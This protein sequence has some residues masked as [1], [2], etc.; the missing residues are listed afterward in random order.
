[1]VGT[2]ARLADSDERIIGSPRLDVRF[3]PA[4]GARVVSVRDT[5]SGREWLVPPAPE[6][7]RPYGASYTEGRL[8]FGWD[9][10]VPTIDECLVGG[11]SY[12]DHGELWAVP[13]T[14]LAPTVAGGMRFAAECRR[15]PLTLEREISVEGDAVA[16]D[17]VLRNRGPIAVAAFWAM[18]PFFAVSRDARVRFSSPVDTA[19]I[20]LPAERRG[21]AAWTEIEALARALP[22][23]EFLKVRPPSGVLSAATIVDGGDALE[24]SWTGDAVRHLALVWDNRTFASTRALA[25]EPMTA[26]GDT[27]LAEDCLRLAA[28]ADARW[29][30]RL[31]V[32]PPVE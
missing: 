4:T 2:R 1:M 20:G 29:R 16:F 7:P 3:R 30:L 23:G 12:P 8:V 17:Y 14:E 31:R 25:I 5:A 22:E 18:H 27:P 6:T 26:D 15:A 19:E 24:V 11:T 13:W 32:P 21:P 10:M 9:E 28:G